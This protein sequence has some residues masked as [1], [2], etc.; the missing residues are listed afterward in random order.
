MKPHNTSLVQQA[1]SAL[2]DEI[3]QIWRLIALN[4][5]LNNEERNSIYMKLCSWHL[6]IIERICKQ[7]TTTTNIST[8][9]NGVYTSSTIN[10]NNDRTLNQRRRD[11]DIFAGFLPAIETCQIDWNNCP[12]CP[13]IIEKSND[14]CSWVDY[15]RY[16]DEI[17]TEGY[18]KLNNNT[19]VNFNSQ[20][21]ATSSPN[22]IVHDV[23][24]ANVQN[25]EILNPNQEKCQDI[26]SGEESC[27]GANV[28]QQ[29]S[30]NSSDECRIYFDDRQAVTKLRKIKITTTATATAIEL[31]SYKI[32]KIINDPL[33]V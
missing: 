19:N 13:D 2:C 22:S 8:T 18:S 31:Y 11:V 1:S 26:D 20:Q 17:L 29:S 21:K 9:T 23:M 10:I 28:D 3:V 7:K 4:P 24:N 16:Y 6:S 33:Q 12:H 30:S 5:P 14:S 27:G 32:L 25:N 15:V